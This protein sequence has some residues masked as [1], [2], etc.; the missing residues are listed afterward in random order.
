MIILQYPH[1]CVAW[2]KDDLNHIIGNP[3]CLIQD[4]LPTFVKIDGDEVSYVAENFGIL[5]THPHTVIYNTNIDP[6]H[7]RK[8]N[9]LVY[10]INQEVNQTCHAHN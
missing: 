5:P 3:Y 10:F 2:T 1:S 6:T 7:R 4:P 9:T 8:I